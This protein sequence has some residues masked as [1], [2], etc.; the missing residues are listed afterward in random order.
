[1][2]S[3]KLTDIAATQPP[4]YLSPHRGAVM[5]GHSVKPPPPA[6]TP[7]RR[8]MRILPSSYN[9]PKAAPQTPPSHA[10]PEVRGMEDTEFNARDAVIREGYLMKLKQT[11]RW[12]K[13]SRW[14]KR[15]FQLRGGFLLYFKRQGMDTP[16]GW[17]RVAQ[18][19]EI[20]ALENNTI[21]PGTNRASENCIAITLHTRHLFL[22]ARSKQEAYDW[23]SSIIT[24]MRAAGVKLPM[25]AALTPGGVR[26]A[27]A[28]PSSPTP[29]RK[30]LSPAQEATQAVHED[31]STPPRGGGEGKSAAPPEMSTPASVHAQV[32]GA[33]G[34]AGAAGLAAISV[35]ATPPSNRRVAQLRTLDVASTPPP[36]S[37]VAKWTGDEDVEWVEYWDD[38][39]QH[40]YY[41][42]TRSNES[43]WEIPHDAEGS[44]ASEWVKCWDYD[45]NCAYYFN[46]RTEDSTYDLPVVLHGV[47]PHW[48]G[49]GSDG[50]TKGM[51]EGDAGGSAD[52]STGLGGAPVVDW[53]TGPASPSPLPPVHG[54]SKGSFNPRTPLGARRGR[55]GDSDRSADGSKSAE[56]SALP[57]PIMA[58]FGGDV[59][60]PSHYVEGGAGPGTPP[61]ASALSELESKGDG[62][63]ATPH[64]GAAP[65]EQHWVEYWDAKY[66]TPYYV[67]STTGES[68]WE[69]PEGEAIVHYDEGEYDYSQGYD[70]TTNTY[71][72]PEGAAGKK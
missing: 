35:P 49:D 72:E 42:N 33:G 14:N 19:R 22:R 28:T 54:S 63:S 40:K 41:V 1:M 12:A 17:L 66:N 27:A 51:E 55:D 29:A 7:E 71:Y 45:F 34:D 5:P 64:R 65:P 32:E 36:K 15:W 13:H 9:P 58:A 8:R 37:P 52:A 16:A 38:T 43:A 31:V 68:V 60:V 70:P 20:K 26:V 69:T 24:C 47:E 50:D 11:H 44:A 21:I 62:E 48:Y 30:L 23:M 2:A 53:T 6:G 3:P 57:D 18:I 56:T 59:F 10:P 25:G 61:A 39:Y 4:G 46:T 67:H